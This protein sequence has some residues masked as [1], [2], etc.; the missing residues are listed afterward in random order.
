MISLLAISGIV[1]LLV[2]LLLL[3]QRKSRLQRLENASKGQTYSKQVFDADK[4]PFVDRIEFHL[5]K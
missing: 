1:V 4:D 2:A 3:R 5:R